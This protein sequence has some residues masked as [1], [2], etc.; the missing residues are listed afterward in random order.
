M[1]ENGKMKPVEI[2][3]GIVGGGENDGGDGFN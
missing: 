2:I 1:Y 3:P